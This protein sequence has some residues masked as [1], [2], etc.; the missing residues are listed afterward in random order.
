[1]LYGQLKFKPDLS[2]EE[3]QEAYDAIYNKTKPQ[4]ASLKKWPD[5]WFPPGADEKGWI[6]WYQQ[7]A[8]GRRSKD[9]ERQIK[10]WNSFKARHGAAFK[11]NPTPRRGFA[12]RNWAIDPIKLL[13]DDKTKK[14][15]EKE[16]TEYH[17]KI[18]SKWNK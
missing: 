15:V 7:Y 3:M 4:L 14:L 8:N 2:A 10:R 11:T 17:S 6:E 13:D 12:L 9:D 5:K 18:E 1:M 16:M